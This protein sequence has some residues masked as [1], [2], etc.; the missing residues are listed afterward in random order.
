MLQ[1]VILFNRLCLH[2]M[3]NVHKPA[4][5]P[6]PSYV[7]RNNMPHFERSA[8]LCHFVGCVTCEVK[9]GLY[10]LLLLQNKTVLQYKVF[11]L[12]TKPKVF[13]SCF[14][15]LCTHTLMKAQYSLKRG[16]DFLVTRK[17]WNND[18]FSLVI[19]KKSR[20]TAAPHDGCFRTVAHYILLGVLCSIL[21]RCFHI[22]INLKSHFMFNNYNIQIIFLATIWKTIA[23]G[24]IYRGLL[25]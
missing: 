5:P 17:I 13:E 21:L 3:L 14:W 23:S 11:S 9:K 24:F 20:V 7:R 25:S 4:T 18:L 12:I 15:W 19:K 1:D 22:Q 8:L 16:C 10:K 6:H 2:L